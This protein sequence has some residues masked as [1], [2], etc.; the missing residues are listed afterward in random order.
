MKKNSKN[1]NLLVRVLEGNK[2]KKLSDRTILFDAPKHKD[3]GQDIRFGGRVVNIEG[4]ETGHIDREGNLQIGGNLKNVFSGRLFKNDFKEIGKEE[5]K[6]EETISK[7]EKELE[8]LHPKSKFDIVKVNTKLINKQIAEEEL[9]E[10][11]DE[12]EFLSI[13]Q[14]SM[15]NIK[16]LFNENNEYASGGKV[17]SVNALMEIVGESA[18]QYGIQPEVLQQLVM[19]ESSG[20]ILTKPNHKGAYGF[21]QFILPTAKSVGLTKQNLISNNY[22]DVKKVADTLARYLANNRDTKFGGDS[23]KM[24]M[25]HNGGEAMFDRIFGWKDFQNY[26]Q[27]IGLNAKSAKDVSGEQ[28]MAYLA[29][30][31]ERVG[32]TY[33]GAYHVETLD[34]TNKIL[35]ESGLSEPISFSTARNTEKNEENQNVTYEPIQVKEEKNHRG[36]MD[37]LLNFEERNKVIGNKMGYNL[38]Q[39][40][41]PREEFAEGGEVVGWDKMYKKVEERAKKSRIDFFKKELV[42]ITNLM[43]NDYITVPEEFEKGLEGDKVEQFFKFYEETSNEWEPSSSRSKRIR[44]MII[45]AVNNNRGELRPYKWRDM[46]A[47]EDLKPYFEGMRS[48][49]RKDWKQLIDLMVDHSVNVPKEGETRAEKVFNFYYDNFREIEEGENVIKNLHDEALKSPSKT[50]GDVPQSSKKL[51]QRRQNPENQSSQNTSSTSEPIDQNTETPDRVEEGNPALKE[52]ISLTEDIEQYLNSP[53]NTS[54]FKEEDA[55]NLANIIGNNF[56]SFPGGSGISIPEKVRQI[57][58]EFLLLG[59]DATLPKVLGKLISENNGHFSQDSI[60]NANKLEEYTGEKLDEYNRYL[61]HY[62]GDEIKARASTEAGYDL[63]DS[64]HLLKGFKEHFDI[65]PNDQEAVNKITGEQ[66]M[67]FFSGLDGTG[68]S[69]DFKDIANKLTPKTYPSSSED[70]EE[71]KSSSQEALDEV[72]KMID[73]YQE[74]KEQGETPT[75]RAEAVINREYEPIERPETKEETKPRNRGVDLRLRLGDIA[76]ELGALFDTPSYVQ[77][78][79]FDPLYMQD[80]R[81][82]FQDRVNQNMSAFNRISQNL[83][84]NPEAMSIMAGQL[85]NANNQVLAEEFRTNQGIMNEVFNQNVNISNQAQLQNIGLRDQQYTRQEQ[86]KENTRQNRRNAVMS[87]SAK[88]QQNRLERQRYDMYSGHF[89]Y[90]LGRDNRLY[91]DEEEHTKKF[92]D[93]GEALYGFEPMDLEQDDTKQEYPIRGAIRDLFRKR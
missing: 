45:D 56:I 87:I 68:K 9:E 92:Q 75:Q 36:V 4:G 16:N 1:P 72:E 89:D 39:V 44:E 71:G 12:K 31:R 62:G 58:E 11:E 15:K 27:R 88:E 61:E 8:E 54:I 3:G 76:P 41:R 46:Q 14:E 17:T 60:D 13:A 21:A 93:R 90:K 32:V 30:R 6:L 86:A 67:E 74:K 91:Y 22:Q 59:E 48:P 81:V 33:K 64:A 66:W 34:Y 37:R 73:D 50:L 83:A 7:I 20:R 23:I 65:D 79:R 57:Q 55:Q 70:T 85:Y 38:G 2:P 78:D 28:F 26:A 24:I 40:L 82:S 51:E 80:Y 19:A 69:A 53:D 52:Y 25:S 10:L 5:A 42:E 43:F 29:D 18:K 35:R 84:D 49:K 47:E 77:G 63:F